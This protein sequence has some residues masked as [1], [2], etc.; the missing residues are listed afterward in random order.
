MRYL[1]L[2]K[3]E[4]VF[5]QGEYIPE[6]LMSEIADASS[7]LAGINFKTKFYSNVTSSNFLPKRFEK[8]MRI[9]ASRGVRWT[10][11]RQKDKE[12]FEKVYNNFVKV[13]N[14]KFK[15]IKWDK[16]FELLAIFY[17]EIKRF[18]HPVLYVGAQFELWKGT[19]LKYP[20]PPHIIPH[21]SAVLRALHF[22]YLL[23]KE[24]KDKA[25]IDL[26]IQ[27]YSSDNPYKLYL[28]RNF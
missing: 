28:I 1:Y 16:A 6:E 26:Y 20:L 10:T 5:T 23:Q 8:F 7:L 14:E 24:Y 15:E 12:F 13:T 4:V 17:P 27:N 11:Y 2:P 21:R 18:I 9:L 25:Q 3:Y 19:Q 22:K